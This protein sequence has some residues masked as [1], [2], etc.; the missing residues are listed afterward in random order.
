MRISSLWLKIWLKRINNLLEVDMKVYD[1]YENESFEKHNKVLRV[2]DLEQWWVFRVDRVLIK[3][4]LGK[5]EY[6]VLEILE[7]GI[8]SLLAE[9]VHDDLIYLALQ[10]AILNLLD[11][12]DHLQKLQANQA[13]MIKIEILEIQIFHLS[14]HSWVTPCLFKVFQRIHLHQ[15]LLAQESLSILHLKNE[16]AQLEDN[17]EKE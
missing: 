6:R 12:V 5:G 3:I 7:E 13:N 10:K 2:L 11:Q 4:W 14:I 1:R 8:H 15:T 16:K 17:D 9:V